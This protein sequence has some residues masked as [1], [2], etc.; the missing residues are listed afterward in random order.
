MTKKNLSI[1]LFLFLIVFTQFNFNSFSQNKTSSPSLVQA[2]ETVIDK[3]VKESLWYV[4]EKNGKKAGKIYKGP[5]SSRENVIAYWYY[6]GIS[7]KK[8]CIAENLKLV[9]SNPEEDL[10]AE[11]KAVKADLE[12]RHSY[13][14]DKYSLKANT[15][16]EK[17]YLSRAVAIKPDKK[18]YEV[19]LHA[20]TNKII[21]NNKTTSDFTAAMELKIKNGLKIYQGDTIVLKWKG[22]SNADIAS[23][24][25]NFLD[26]TE[27]IAT[28]LPAGSIFEG[29]K[30]FVALENLSDKAMITLMY[31]GGTA[32]AAK[33]VFYKR[34]D[35]VNLDEE[36]KLQDDFFTEQEPEENT[37]DQQEDNAESESSSMEEIE[38]EPA[39]EIKLDEDEGISNIK[40]FRREYLND[41]AIEDVVPAPVEPSEEFKFDFNV[42]E[43]SERGRTMLMDACAAG[44]EWQIKKL[45][46]AGSRINATDKD[47]WTAL[48][49]A[50]RYCD[51]VAALNLL[52]NAKADVKTI[53]K[54]DSSALILAACYNNNPDVIK[55]LLDYYSISEKEVVKAFVL[56]LSSNS[57]SE[58]VQ[59]AKIMVFINK[60]I[61]I[62]TFY[63][64]KT[65]LMYAAQYG[66][67]TEVLKL[68]LENDAVVGIRSTEGKT[69]F[70]Y[71]KDNSKL[72]H[73]DIYWS[74]NNK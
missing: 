65:P 3:P 46:E 63:N 10:S 29:H 73:D 71:A 62:N 45:I 36:S 42:N 14:L 66:N 22:K 12:E 16:I 9:T 26:K 18:I 54:F 2:K 28:N 60:D 33:I 55:R 19:D 52:L 11:Y 40:R 37:E 20:V 15:K 39:F 8:Y 47:G 13:A 72:K 25:L 61:P 1:K 48:M 32:D 67:S 68:L 57:G 4:C 56:L 24:K 7:G 49:Y 6:M 35:R 27:E 53:N 5:F 69:A 70:E 44:N 58:F 41:Y 59:K 34:S 50:A 17:K 43:T 38:E 51:N 21:F 30:V 64:G 31:D 74:L 23:L